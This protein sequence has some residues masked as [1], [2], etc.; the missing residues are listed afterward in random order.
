M[1]KKG[2]KSEGY[3]NL[4]DIEQGYTGGRDGVLEISRFWIS[5]E[6]LISFVNEI[7]ADGGENEDW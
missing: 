5:A 2:I 3:N 4:S 7:D 1:N 6:D